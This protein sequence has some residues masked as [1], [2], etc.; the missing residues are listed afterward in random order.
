MQNII[1]KKGARFLNTLKRQSSYEPNW[2]T[3]FLASH[4]PTDERIERASDKNI[5]IYSQ[6]SP[7]V[8][9]RGYWK[10]ALFRGN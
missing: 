9:K 3:N 2:M 8:S 4:P 7:D 10:R 1:L 5:E 6:L